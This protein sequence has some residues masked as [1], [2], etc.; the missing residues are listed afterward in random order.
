MIFLRNYAQNEKICLW[1]FLILPKIL[2]LSLSELFVSRP[3]NLDFPISQIDP[4]AWYYLQGH[5]PYNAIASKNRH[6]LKDSFLKYRTQKD[7]SYQISKKNLLLSHLIQS[8]Q[9]QKK[10]KLILQ[11]HGFLVKKWIADKII[12]WNQSTFLC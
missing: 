1:C 5:L 6:H 10:P 4:L 12:K 3:I 7:Y 8:K 9:H 2:S 11:K